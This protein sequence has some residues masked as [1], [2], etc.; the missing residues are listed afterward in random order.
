[1]GVTPVLTASPG[2]AANYSNGAFRQYL[3][4]DAE[5]IV[6]LP[7]QVSFEDAATLGMGISTAGQALY[8]VLALPVPEVEPTPKNQT[9]LIYGGSTATGSLAIQFAK[10]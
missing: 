8:Q 3:N 6:H 10:L 4:V 2:H 1:V 5:L 7:D 9:I